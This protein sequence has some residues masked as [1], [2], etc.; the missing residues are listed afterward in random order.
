MKPL[1]PAVFLLRN[2]GKALPFVGVIVLSVLLIMGIV[3]MMNSIPLSIRTT[4]GYAKKL[5]AIT[6]RG[7]PTR[8]P[9][10]IDKLSKAPVK[11]ERITVCRAC[12]A[13]VTSIVG[14]WDFAVFGMSPEDAE[15]FLKRMEVSR[16]DGRMPQKGMPEAI[17]SEPVSRNLK[18]K[19][20]DSL[21]KPTN[22]EMY[23]PKSVKVVGV[24]QTSQ[25]FM[26]AD[27]DYLRENHFPPVDNVVV[28]GKTPE[29][30]VQLD[31][32]AEKEYKGERSYVFAYHIM[33]KDT[34]SMF[35]I[36]YGILDI[37]IYTLVAVIT[38]MMG[39]LMNIQLSQ[40]TAEFALLQALGLT[41]I[42]ILKRILW[43]TSL[44]LLV[45]WICG[46]LCA[47][48]LLWVTKMQMFDKNAFALSIWDP[49]AVRYTVPVPIAIFVAAL[50]TLYFRFRKFDPVGVVER[51]IV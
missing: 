48:F 15:Y 22:Q 19:L 10:I 23:S 31:H 5:L 40:R 2:P 36:L 12:Y 11:P 37:V 8:V 42:A 30:Q 34:N 26:L 28:F 4:Y 35:R 6:P 46:V 38:L 49:V 18:L 45:G 16:L 33:E 20:G 39:M 3:S 51:R 7:D 29:D 21:L 14:K 25:W 32:W 13:Q 47:C 24:A 17:I 9:D 44:V 43:E 27:I 1:S 41:R 50:L